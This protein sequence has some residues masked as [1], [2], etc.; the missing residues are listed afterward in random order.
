[1]LRVR[2][3]LPSVL[4][5]AAGAQAYAEVG[6]GWDLRLALGGGPGVSQAKAD[7]GPT[8]DIDDRGA[9]TIRF[10]AYWTAPIPGPV[11]LQLGPTLAVSRR[12]GHT[13]AGG[14]FAVS[15]SSVGFAI[16][17][18]LRVERW[19]FALTPYIDL[20][21]GREHDDAGDSDRGG[22]AA[23][24]MT[25]SAMYTFR[26]HLILGVDLGGEGWSTKVHQPVIDHDVTYSGGGAVLDFF[27]GIKL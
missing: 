4:L 7:G 14:D 23:L 2:H 17:P 20:G 10:S 21:S 9:G 19:R 13:E 25:V 3:L 26:N 5:V 15:E 8:T 6:D 11:G 12:H 1:M 27:I 24:G 18:I 16:G 22:Y